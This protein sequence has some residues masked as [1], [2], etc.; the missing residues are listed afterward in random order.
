[1]ANLNN[2]TFDE[3]EIN[4]EE[5]NETKNLA[6]KNVLHNKIK[7]SIKII[8]KEIEEYV[9]IID[10][11]DINLTNK[12]IE[13]NKDDDIDINDDI[14]NIEKLLK[15]KPE[16]IDLEIKHYEKLINKIKNVKNKSIL[17]GINIINCN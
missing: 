7:E 14:V 9:N 1:M 17:S 12:I 16:N 3:L 6:K 8:E 11:I 5:L 2:D 10:D 15:E 4:V 13:D